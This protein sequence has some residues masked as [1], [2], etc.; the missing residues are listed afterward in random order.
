MF[1]K[2]GYCPMLWDF[3]VWISALSVNGPRSQ[4]TPV[5]GVDCLMSNKEPV[6]V[7]LSCSRKTSCLRVF[8]FL[9]V[10]VHFL[11]HT[12]TY[13]HTSHTCVHAWYS[14]ITQLATCSLVVVPQLAT[15][16][17]VFFFT[18]CLAFKNLTSGL[19]D[20]IDC[21]SLPIF[22]HLLFTPNANTTSHTYITDTQGLL[23]LHMFAI[24]CRSHGVILV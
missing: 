21:L 23:I 3:F 11:T 14:S 20:Y 4:H 17:I 10:P 2:I 6:A 9:A 13:T 7:T 18:F 1:V 12:H 24:S 19:G 15:A 5:C 22:P 8:S 16:A